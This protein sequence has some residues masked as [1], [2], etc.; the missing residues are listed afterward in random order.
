MKRN[1]HKHNGAALQDCFDE[2]LQHVNSSNSAPTIK[3]QVILYGMERTAERARN[4]GR[5]KRAESP[6][7][8]KIA[9]A[10]LV[11]DAWTQHRNTADAETEIQ[12]WSTLHLWVALEVAGET[13]EKL[14]NLH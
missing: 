13:L 14:E 7:E 12:F 2:I 6:E 1:G 3:D 11:V 5:L 9:A 4:R 10:W 8:F